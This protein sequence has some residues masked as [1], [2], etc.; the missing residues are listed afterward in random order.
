MGFLPHKCGVFR[1]PS[2]WTLSPSG[3]HVGS[4]TRYQATCCRGMSIS[5]CSC[6]DKHMTPRNL[7]QQQQ[8]QQQVELR[9]VVAVAV[10]HSLELRICS[11]IS[12]NVLYQPRTTWAV[13]GLPVLPTDAPSRTCFFCNVHNS[14]SHPC[15]RKR[16]ASSRA[17]RR[18]SQAASQ[19]EFS[20]SFGSRKV[21]NLS[22]G[23]TFR[24]DSQPRFTLL[25]QPR[26]PCAR[27]SLCLLRFHSP[28]LGRHTY[29]EAR[30]LTPLPPAS[31]PTICC[32]I[33]NVPKISS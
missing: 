12:P 30:A 21:W 31:V 32:Q 22:F 16:T 23:M 17:H 11:F 28:T 18:H 3:A 20:C 1:A 5:S 25:V 4:H 29:P 13:G 15:Y 8:Q 27:T 19:S 26:N 33:S 14:I 10:P 24:F 2:I 9:L 7:C 6:V